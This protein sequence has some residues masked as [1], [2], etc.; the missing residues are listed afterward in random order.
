MPLSRLSAGIARKIAILGTSTKDHSADRL[1]NPT[2][3]L[4]RCDPRLFRT[5]RS[6]W[7]DQTRKNT[8]SEDNAFR[9]LYLFS[10][11]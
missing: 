6:G 2:A 3:L 1:I 4:L 7:R 5:A 8:Y 10:S 11:T 9:E